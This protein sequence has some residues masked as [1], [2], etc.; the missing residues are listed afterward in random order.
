[1]RH[2]VC[3][4]GRD[5][6]RGPKRTFVTR[7]FHALLSSSPNGVTTA[8]NQLPAHALPNDEQRHSG[9]KEL[10]PDEARGERRV[11]SVRCP[12]KRTRPPLLVRV[13]AAT[14]LFTIPGSFAH[15]R[16]KEHLRQKLIDSGW[17]D[18]LKEYTMGARPFFRARRR[19]SKKVRAWE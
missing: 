16:L 9:A 10:D 17:R 3:L 6:E 13:A 1:M 18:N 7:L 15:R 12:A 14:P 4:V 2:G 5:A 19:R 8:E 11:R